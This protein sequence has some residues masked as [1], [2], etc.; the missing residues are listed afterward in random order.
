MQKQI[1]RV[2]TRKN[3]NSNQIV[4]DDITFINDNQVAVLKMWYQ[5]SNTQMQ[6][7]FYQTEA[8][9][10]Y[11]Q[12]FAKTKDLLLLLNGSP[13]QNFFEELDKLSINHVKSTGLIKKLALNPKEVKYRTIVNEINTVGN[14]ETIHTTK[15]KVTDK[16]KFYVQ[17]NKKSK[18]FE[19]VHHI[20]QA[21]SNVK[22]IIEI[23]SLMIDIKSSVII[24]KLVLHQFRIEKVIPLKIE[25]NE[26][27]FVDS[28]EDEHEDEHGDE[29]EDEH[30]NCNHNNSD[31]NTSNHN[32]SDHNTSNH[33]NSDHN[34]HNEIEKIQSEDES[35]DEDE[36]END[37][38]VSMLKSISV[39]NNVESDNSDLAE[40][41]SSDESDV[42]N[43][44]D[45]E[46]DEIAIED[47][48][49][50]INKTKI[51]TPSK[52]APIK[53]DPVVKQKSV[54]QIQPHVQSL[55]QE[56]KPR[57]RPKK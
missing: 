28:D 1:E 48:V 49:S 54:V 22:A 26:Y 43:S 5:H 44:Y 47:F 8:V 36:S 40:S 46:S 2:L 3:I 52:I 37:E 57:G 15:V 11:S 33:N 51:V 38:H 12:D 6:S 31:H 9:Q 21:G 39:K 32:N 34:S 7:L 42:E 35:E 30:I 14:T 16:T 53:Q 27:S 4:Y 50:A 10:L 24:T 20:L 25:L 19:D 29:D 41:D 18:S 13:E 45:E 56:K 55:L 17:G 23:D